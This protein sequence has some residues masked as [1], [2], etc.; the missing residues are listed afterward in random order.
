[1]SVMPLGLAKVGAE[2]LRGAG[3]AGLGGL[4]LSVDWD[5]RAPSL[6]WQGPRVDSIW[7]E[8]SVCRRVGSW[9]LIT[10]NKIRCLVG[11]TGER[12]GS[13]SLAALSVGAGGGGLV[14]SGPVS[15]RYT[16]QQSRSSWDL[17]FLRCLEGSS[18]WVVDGGG[19]GGGAAGGCP[20]Q[21]MGPAEVRQV[22]TEFLEL[23]SLLHI[24]IW[25]LG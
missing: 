13:G 11:S 23:E 9:D 21:N 10:P 25:V 7:G 16:S 4:Q 1:M 14:G 6:L 19:L 24:K 22:R 8:Q 2:V 18:S 5:Y 3:R 17:S 12:Q 20:Q 15:M